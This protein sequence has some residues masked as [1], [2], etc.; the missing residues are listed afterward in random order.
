MTNRQDEHPD[1]RFREALDTLPTDAPAPGTQFNANALWEQ[2][3]PELAAQ[4]I[5]ARQR[6]WPGWWL[7]VASLVGVL[8]GGWWWLVQ[9]TQP[10]QMV[11]T[12]LPPQRTQPG[13]VAKNDQQPTNNEPITG[14]IKNVVPLH[15]F[16]QKPAESGQRTQPKP[17]ASAEAVADVP[18][19][20]LSDT[21]VTYPVAASASSTP[22]K[23]RFAVVHQNELRSDAETQ[24]K[25][26]RNDRFV[27]LGIPASGT[28]QK[29]A[30]PTTETSGLIISLN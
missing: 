24:A 29:S 11:V 18:A 8:L 26:E 14:R 21:T 6:T 25:L 13:I 1:R 17:V 20:V 15:R 30:A 9:R 5:A 7:A 27:R 28:L 22:P 19:P 12:Q 10:V 3:R 2:L 4:P 16:P 23:R